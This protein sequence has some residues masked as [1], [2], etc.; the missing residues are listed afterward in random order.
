MT[1]PRPALPGK[2]ALP[3]ADVPPLAVHRFS[4][5]EGGVEGWLVVDTSVAGL[6]FGGFRFSP[7]VTEAE[8]R[9]LAR[10]M[11]W[12][13]AGHGL[14]VGGAKAG[15][16]V[17]P[18]RPDLPALLERVAAA[19]REP[20]ETSVVL[21]K[22]MGATDLL[23]DALYRGVGRPQLEI[24]RRRHGAAGVPERLRDLSG[25]RRH[26]TG[27]GVSWAVEEALG[28]VVSGARVAVQGFGTVGLG[29]AVRLSE[30]GAVVVAISDAEG[31]ARR[32][33]GLTTSVL[34]GIARPGGAFDRAGLP[35]GAVPGA[36]DDL[37][38]ADCDVLVLAASSGS[39]GAALAEGIGAPP[40]L[41]P[42]VVEG[43]NFGLT[44]EAREVLQ[45]RG[46]TVVPDILASS[47]SAAMA[48]RQMA[49]GNNLSA[50]RLWEEVRSAIRTSTRSALD[51]AARRGTDVRTAWISEIS[52]EATSS[53]TIAAPA[54]GR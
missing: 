25:Y 24:V 35:A 23:L 32:A 15:L 39:V 50:D 53:G 13:L 45:R 12:K 54:G 11:T 37:L 14:P 29:A 49:S 47:A 17:D 21:G 4:E 5:P 40:S 16:A 19:W 48:T 30:I 2:P 26:M 36:R 6:S 31:S 8:V 43:A 18:R 42:L 10:C 51:A 41:P 22:D 1:E 3:G 7:A 38:A 9:D 52:S 34:E 44:G 20:L 46:V 27:L 28:G 33:E